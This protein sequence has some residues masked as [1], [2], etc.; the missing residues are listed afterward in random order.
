MFSYLIIFCLKLRYLNRYK[1]IYNVLTLCQPL[2]VN[3]TIFETIINN[4]YLLELFCSKRVS[5]Y[6]IT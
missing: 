5:I 1:L 6:N 4:N 3:N 2:V